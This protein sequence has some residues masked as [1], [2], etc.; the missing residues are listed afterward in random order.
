MKE[1]EA[2]LYLSA[3]DL[4]DAEEIYEEKLFELKQFFLN[5]FPVSKLIQS[6]L[7]TFLK[8]EQAYEVL[9]GSISGGLQLPTMEFPTIESLQAAFSWYHKEK[10][11]I[12]LH[13]LAAQSHADLQ[14][15]LSRYID[16]A[17]HYAKQ[18]QV[19]L[20]DEDKVG[21]AIGVEPDAMEIQAELRVQKEKG[22]IDKA[23]ILSLPNENCLKS[24]AKRLSLWLKFETNG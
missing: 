8:V 21:I 15:V 6:K 2:L 22:F 17:Q 16:I 11:A 9:G 23:F 13:L 19:P 20:A 12:R 24:E 3:E 5:R 7:S 18:W 14:R 1:E 4:D 10:N